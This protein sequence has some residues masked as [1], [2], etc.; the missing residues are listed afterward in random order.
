MPGLGFRINR[1]ESGEIELD[2]MTERDED[3]L[4]LRPILNVWEG[5]AD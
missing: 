2:E 3:A 1:T 4:F 5:W